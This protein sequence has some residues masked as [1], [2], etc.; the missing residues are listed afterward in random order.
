VIAFLSAL[1]LDTSVNDTKSV[2]VE[3]LAECSILTATEP[4]TEVHC[5][6][7]D[8]SVDAPP[9]SLTVPD[10]LAVFVDK[11]NSETILSAQIL[12]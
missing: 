9:L 6:Y 3:L 7:A 1:M 10:P 11:G 12:D 5:M 4:V 2:H 8:P